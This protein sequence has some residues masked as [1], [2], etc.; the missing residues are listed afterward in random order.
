LA[1]N[2]AT[3]LSFQSTFATAGS[4]AGL[5]AQGWIMDRAGAGATWLAAGALSMLQV[6][7][8]LALRDRKK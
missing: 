5:P 2:G 1:A 8:Y 4:I 3:L 7:C 6:P